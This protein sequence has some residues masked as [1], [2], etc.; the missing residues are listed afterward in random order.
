[1]R[2]PAIIINILA[3]GVLIYSF[4]K[5]RAKTRQGLRIAYRAIGR[6][7]PMMVNILLMVALIMGFIDKQF[8]SSWLG[9]AQNG[10]NIVIA[11]LLGSVLM[12]PS[13]VGFPLAASLLLKGASLTAIATFITTLT[14]IGVVTLPLEIKEMGGRFA[15]LR[16][17]LSLIVAVVIGLLI[18]VLL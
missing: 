12:I 5:D 8:I 18:G 2:S 10:W 3:L 1:M 13:L 16:N 4:F 15:L 14:M 7:L 17:G 6:L 9:S 11:A